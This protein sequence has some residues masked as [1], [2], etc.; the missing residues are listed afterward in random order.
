MKINFYGYNT[1]LIGSGNKKIAFGLDC[2]NYKIYE[3]NIT[4]EMKKQIV[5][6]T[7]KDPEEV[8]C[9]GYRLENGINYARV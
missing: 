7:Q 6:K 4:K 1:F 8:A 5:L 3:E 9:K 2:F